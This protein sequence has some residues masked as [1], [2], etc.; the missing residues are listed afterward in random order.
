MN[1]AY[2]YDAVRTPFGKFNG[3]LS[4]IRPDRAA[5]GAESIPICSMRARSRSSRRWER[6]SSTR[7]TPSP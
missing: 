7:P 4:G 2:I 3:A 5:I 6:H 1:E